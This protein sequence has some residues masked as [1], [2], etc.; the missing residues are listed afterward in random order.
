MVQHKK[1][2]W[3]NERTVIRFHDIFAP[4]KQ[5]QIQNLVQVASEVVH[6]SNRIS[7][8]TKSNFSKHSKTKN[9]FFLFIS[10]KFCY[11]V[12]YFIYNIWFD[13]VFVIVKEIDGGNGNGNKK[14]MHLKKIL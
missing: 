9:N 1:N 7:M 10:F 6:R 12:K 14:L 11:F 5:K 2:E 3:M 8:K 13:N 4:K